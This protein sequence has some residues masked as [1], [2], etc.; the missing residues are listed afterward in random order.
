[1]KGFS[2]LRHF[3]RETD[4][5]YQGG[6]L[7]F[8]LK[9]SDAV[10][11]EFGT[12]RREYKFKAN[13]ARR[14]SNEQINPTL[15]ELGVTAADLGQ[16]FKFGDGLDLPAGAPTSFFAPNIDAFREAIGF[17][18]NCLNKYGDFRLSYLAFPGSQYVVNEYDKSYF[19]QVNWDVQLFDHRNL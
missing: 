11:F 14:L 12:T 1:M 18:C 9:V 5:D 17:D 4:N 7:N 2:V 8:E 19:A 3:E 15:A 16:V 6:H 13:E 10:G